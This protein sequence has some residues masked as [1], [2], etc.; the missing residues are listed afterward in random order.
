MRVP[1]N[2]VTV[3]GWKRLYEQAKA[4]RILQDPD[5]DNDEF[6]VTLDMRDGT[7]RYLIGSDDELKA[8]ET[9]QLCAFLRKYTNVKSF[10]LAL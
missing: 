7:V 6:F 3:R 8:M 5:A 9:K 4:L 2:A 1:I 10:N